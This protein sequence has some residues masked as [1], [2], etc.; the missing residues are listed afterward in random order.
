MFPRDKM[1]AQ[2]WNDL[3]IK[4]NEKFDE[5]IKIT[6]ERSLENLSEDSLE[7]FDEINRVRKIESDEGNDVYDENLI[8]ISELMC[9]NSLF[10]NGYDVEKFYSQALEKELKNLIPKTRKKTTSTKK[11]KTVKKTSKKIKISLEVSHGIINF[12]SFNQLQTY[13]IPRQVNFQS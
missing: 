7:W 1:N 2:E 13:M 10:Q 12:R 3:R 5:W 4:S 8:L 6:N 11:P 9:L